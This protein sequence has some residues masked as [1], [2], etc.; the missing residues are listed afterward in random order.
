M[1]VFGYRRPYMAIFS[2]IFQYPLKDPERG[3][4]GPTRARP[5]VI[6]KIIKNTRKTKNHKNVIDFTISGTRGSLNDPP[7]PIFLTLDPPNYST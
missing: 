4:I 1:A 7:K 5:H 6:S 2:Y 3:P